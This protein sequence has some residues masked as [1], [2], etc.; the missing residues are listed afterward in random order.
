MGNGG[1]GGGLVRKKKVAWGD[2][3]LV[4]E[5]GKKGGKGSD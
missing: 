5:G 3:F 2:C 1:G 4:L